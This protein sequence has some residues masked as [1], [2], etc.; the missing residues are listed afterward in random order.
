[1]TEY[2]SIKW[3]SDNVATRK[4]REVDLKAV[5]CPKVQ[6]FKDNGIVEE[7]GYAITVTGTADTEHH[8]IEDTAILLKKMAEVK[9]GGGH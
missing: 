6:F 7:N 8:L 2:H 1:M 3:I 9:C 5:I 4:T